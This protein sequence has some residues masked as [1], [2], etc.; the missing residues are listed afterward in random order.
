MSIPPVELVK[1]GR[2]YKV[3]SLFVDG[4]IALARQQHDPQ[5][6]EE[7]ATALGW[8]V[9]ARIMWAISSRSRHPTSIFGV[10]RNLAKCLSCSATLV[11]QEASESAPPVNF[12]A[13]GASHPVISAHGP[14]GY[15]MVPPLIHPNPHL[16]GP[17]PHVHLT[18][19]T[20]VGPGTNVHLLHPNG[21]SQQLM[22]QAQQQV[23]GSS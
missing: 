21:T 15:T 4:C 6:L 14:T 20:T 22:L 7:L 2:E 23:G 16:H 8:D 19:P 18:A 10:P 13:G 5:Q 17:G 3:T 9:A 1:L 12:G 11:M